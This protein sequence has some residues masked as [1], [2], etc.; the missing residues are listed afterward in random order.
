VRS[1]NTIFV[2][3]TAAF[4][5]LYAVGV[6]VLGPISFLPIQV[7]VADALLPLAIIFGWP[8]ILGLSIG[9][10]VANFFGGLGA[11]DIIGGSIAN[12]IATFVAWRIGRDRSKPWQLL[13]VGIEIVVITLLVGTYLTY[14]FGFPLAWV[15]VFA[16]S[17]IAI[18]ILGSILL[19]AMSRKRVTG[20]LKAYGLGHES[21]SSEVKG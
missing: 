19:F 1:K 6:I 11:V 14:V 8:A 7:R 18:G 17:V 3:L 9:A 21:E 16:G 20:M 2:S 10:F 12:F 5:A 4:A 15:G 13:G